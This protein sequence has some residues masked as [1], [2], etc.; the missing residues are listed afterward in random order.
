[1]PELTFIASSF[2]PEEDEPLDAYSKAAVPS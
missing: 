2:G 1:M